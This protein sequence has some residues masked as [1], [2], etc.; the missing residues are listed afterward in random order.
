MNPRGD[1]GNDRTRGQPRFLRDGGQRRAGKEGPRREGK[2]PQG[3]L[4][5]SCGV[6]IGSG[7][8]AAG[9]SAGREDD[10]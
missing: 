5:L 3:W 6:K 9:A 8:G 2:H 7:A 10:G 4:V 1:S